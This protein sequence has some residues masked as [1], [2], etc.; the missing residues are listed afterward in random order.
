MKHGKE[1][2]K[3]LFEIS[4]AKRSAWQIFIVIVVVVILVFKV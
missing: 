3:T 4:R 2:K 1:K